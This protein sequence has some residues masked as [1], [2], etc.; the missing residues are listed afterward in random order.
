M[1]QQ[2]AKQKLRIALIIPTVIAAGLFTA[3]MANAD[4][5]WFGKGKH[6]GSEHH[7]ERMEHLSDMLDMSDDQETQLKA[8]LKNAKEQ[9]KANKVS[10]RGMRQAMMSIS[11]DDPQFMTKVEEQADIAAANMKAK[12]L[13]FAQVRQD[14]YAILTEEQK[15]KMQRMIEKR[16]KKMERR[17]GDDDE[18]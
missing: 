5:G 3:S 1:R 2:P 12:M 4:S 17:W 7:Y 15:Q 9:G 11:P 16:M 18:E 13:H 14:V 8:I 10:R 6:Y